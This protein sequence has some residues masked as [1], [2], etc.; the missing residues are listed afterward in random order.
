MAS[1]TVLTH[2]MFW[3]QG[4]PFA[5][6]DPGDPVPCIVS[7]LA[8]IWKQRD[9]DVLCLQ[10]VQSER[11]FNTV[12]TAIAALGLPADGAYTAGYE[13]PQYGGALFHRNGRIV[14]DS[15]ASDARPHR[16]WQL[17]DIPFG[18][19][20]LRIANVHLPSN[21]QL[22]PEQSAVKR[23]D[24][25]RDMLGIAGQPDLI[26]GDHNERPGGGVT[27]FL[28]SRGYRDVAEITGDS[29]GSSLSGPKRIDYIWVSDRIADRVTG[30]GVIPAYELA[31]TCAGREY[32]SDHLPLWVRIG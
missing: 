26:C 20:R 25:L 23:V 18:S 24:E 16:M 15:N 32:L 9:P 14:T 5:S 11:A 27:Q 2:N 1:C 21:R 8:Q 30:Y 10:E 6:A 31:V 22:P 7:G 19:D 29:S 28:T 4:V 13:Y 12:R 17:A 3:G